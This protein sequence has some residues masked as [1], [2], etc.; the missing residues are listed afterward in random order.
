[1]SL[2]A[3]A[4]LPFIFGGGSGG[5]DSSEVLRQA[6]QYTDGQVE[7]ALDEA[8]DYT[9]NAALNSYVVSE[10]TTGT[11]TLGTGWSATEPYSIAVTV[12]GYTVTAKT[13]VSIL[14]NAAA[15]IQM[16]NDGVHTM[17]ITNDNGTLTAYATGNKPSVSM[18]VPVLFT[19]VE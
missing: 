8:K 16:R 5:G 7:A 6:K 19:E 1:M 15:L 14:P 11:V 18:T 3:E 9:D 12:S 2:P 4:L 13:M 17:Y 10:G